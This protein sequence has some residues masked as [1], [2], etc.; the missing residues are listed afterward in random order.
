MALDQLLPSVQPRSFLEQTRISFE[1]F[2]AEFYPIL[3]AK[4]LQVAFRNV[5][6]G[7]LFLTLVSETEN[8]GSVMLKTGD[9]AGQGR[10]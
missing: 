9:R 2:L 5:G 6:G 1:Q 4:Q 8:S 3:L 10:V 7:N